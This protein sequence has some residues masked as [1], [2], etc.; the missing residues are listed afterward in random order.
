MFLGFISIYFKE[1]LIN[2]IELLPIY[3]GKNF[4]F[5]YN[6]SKDSLKFED[7]FNDLCQVCQNA[8]KKTTP[9]PETRQAD[10]SKKF[11]QAEIGIIQMVQSGMKNKAMAAKLG[12]QQNTLSSMKSKLNKKVKSLNMTFESYPNEAV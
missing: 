12:V 11:T 2:M 8:I 7:P 9:P 6:H 4:N 5:A 10:V 3:D 1:F